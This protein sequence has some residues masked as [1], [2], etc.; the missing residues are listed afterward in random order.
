MQFLMGKMQV[1]MEYA[2]L[3]MHAHRALVVVVLD[4]TSGGVDH[5][6]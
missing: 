6:S 1:V 4:A 5:V 3:A 2:T